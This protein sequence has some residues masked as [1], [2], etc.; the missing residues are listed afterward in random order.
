MEN[1]INHL[2]KSKIDVDSPDEFIKVNKLI[3]KT[4]Q[5][6][7]S[8]SHKVFTDE[9]NKIVLSSGDDKRMN[10]IGSIE[11]YALGNRRD[12][13]F[14]KEEIK[15]NAIIKHMFNFDYIKKW[16][17]TKYNPNWLEIPDH[18]YR[19]WTVGGSESGKT[20][21]LLNLINNEP[22]IDKFYLY[23]K[24]PDEAKYK[25]LIN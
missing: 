7:K 5:R 2:E 12:L 21:M 17:L 24:N 8:E 23:A 4:Q 1:K 22:N 19:I 16:G 11:T 18:P 25:M 14:K 13:V 6:F 10:S 15:C 3:L 9:I 20:N